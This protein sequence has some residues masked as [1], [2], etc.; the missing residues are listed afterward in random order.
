MLFPA[1]ITESMLPER[2]F[3][4]INGETLEIQIASEIHLEDLID[5]QKA[6]Y[7]GDTPWGRIT[8]ANELRNKNSFVLV[9]VHRGYG[10]AFMAVALR[11][12]RMHITNIATKPNYQKQGLATFFI[13]TCAALGAELDRKFITLEVRMS[14][15]DA[16]RLYRKLGFKDLYVKKGYY[17]DNNE[18]ALEMSYTI[19]Q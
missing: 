3:K 19:K 6:C 13:E 10:V 11:D 1:L 16:K 8:I 4:L 12:D 7:Y 9:A 15:E 17:H 2:E 18:D 5:I 14:N